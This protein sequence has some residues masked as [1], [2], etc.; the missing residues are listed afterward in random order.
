MIVL[1]HG[2]PPEFWLMPVFAIAGLLVGI[3]TLVLLRRTSPVYT[4]GCVL[5]LVCSAATFAC[6]LR[7]GDSLFDLRYVAGYAPSLILGVVGL[8]LRPPP[9]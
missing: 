5:T 1:A 8:V 2:P 9:T 6:T 7:G 4:V 3:F